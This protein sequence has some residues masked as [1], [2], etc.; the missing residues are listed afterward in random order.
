MAKQVFRKI[1]LKTIQILFCF[2]QIGWIK[3][4]LETKPKNIRY[5]PQLKKKNINYMKH[6]NYYNKTKYH[7]LLTQSARFLTQSFKSEVVSQSLR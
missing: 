2:L 1:L 7:I 5:L 3:Q 4:D 6:T